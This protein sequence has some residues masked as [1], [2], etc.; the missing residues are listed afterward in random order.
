MA[1]RAC[2]YAGTMDLYGRVQGVPT[3]LDWKS[4]RAIYGEALLQ[5]IAYRHA[6]AQTGLPATQGLIVSLRRQDRARA[7]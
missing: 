6:A 4:G 7:E 5:N 3:I 1:C 2:G